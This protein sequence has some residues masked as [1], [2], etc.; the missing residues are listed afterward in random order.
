MY[1]APRFD[2]EQTAAMQR[3]FKKA[4]SLVELRV[5]VA[6]RALAKGELAQLIIDAASRGERNAEEL[7]RRARQAFEIG[8]GT[9][10]GTNVH[11]F[12]PNDRLGSRKT[13]S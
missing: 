13:V 6:L 4:W 1:E 10:L 7:C 9:N 8:H 2:S 11:K 3:A 12:K 5:P